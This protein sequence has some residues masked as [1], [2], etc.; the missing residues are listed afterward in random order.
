MNGKWLS[1]RMLMNKR[2]WEAA[3]AQGAAAAGAFAALL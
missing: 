3:E 2:E 1:V